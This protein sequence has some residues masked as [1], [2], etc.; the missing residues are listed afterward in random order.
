MEIR[1]HHDQKAG[2]QSKIR[3]PAERSAQATYHFM[4][5]PGMLLLLLFNF[6]PM[7]GII[8]AP[9]KLPTV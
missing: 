1:A 9:D 2:K 7:F 8:M 3:K 4:M 6:L 5:L